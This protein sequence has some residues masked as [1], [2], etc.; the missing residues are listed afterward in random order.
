MNYVE[1]HIQH[2]GTTVAYYQNP[3]WSRVTFYRREDDG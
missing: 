2:Y 1:L 3:E